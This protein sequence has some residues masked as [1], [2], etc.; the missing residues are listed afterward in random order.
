M[1]QSEAIAEQTN[2]VAFTMASSVHLIAFLC[3][4][5]IGGTADSTCVNDDNECMYGQCYADTVLKLKM[6]KS[7]TDTVS[8]LK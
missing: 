4:W 1:K 3:R 7:Y 6:P 5:C 8:K 2:G